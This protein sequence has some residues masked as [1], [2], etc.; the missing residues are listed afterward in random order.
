MNQVEKA[1]KVFSLRVRPWDLA[2]VCGAVLTTASVLAFFGSFWWFLDLFSHFRIQYSLA[3]SVVALVLL[4]PRRYTVSAFFGVITIVNFGTIVPLYFGKEPQPT[5]ASRSYRGLL[6]NVN[7]EFGSPEKAA[8]AIK[9]VDADFVV[10][11]EIN[12]HW[13]SAL[14]VSLRGYPY[15]R[16]K[17]RDD[18][19]GIALYS[20]YPFTRSEIRQVGEANI[21]SVVAEIASPDGRLTVIATHPLPPI[22]RE[23]S[24]LRN[25]QLGRLPE[26]VKQANSPVLLLGDLNATPWCSHFKRSLR[27]SGLRDSSQG[28]GVLPTWPTWNPMLLI[29]IDHCLHT[30]DIHV[31]RKAT[32]PN[33]GSDHYPIVVDFVL[34]APSLT[35]RQP[36]AAPNAAPP[37]R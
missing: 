22:G 9:Q 21:P 8:A 11:E 15:S 12:N 30:A 14:S 28:R 6:M 20:K 3:L 17:P 4:F 29:P 19:F 1:A 34:S 27:Q 32:G 35:N 24:R 37:P 7:T 13:M 18:N 10:L 16:A 5:H 23:N 2:T 31:M 26:I 33:M 25:E 36:I